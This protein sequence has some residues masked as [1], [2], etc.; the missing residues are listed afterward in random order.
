MYN[1]KEL[2]KETGLGDFKECYY[3][4]RINFV[5][6]LMTERLK[7]DIWKLQGPYP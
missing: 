6:S 3:W 7:L 2:A 4:L 5:P 1:L